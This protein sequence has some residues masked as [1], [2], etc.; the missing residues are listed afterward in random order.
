MFSDFPFSF[1]ESNCTPLLLVI[2]APCVDNYFPFS[3]M[4]FYFCFVTFFPLKLLDSSFVLIIIFC[5]ILLVLPPF[6]T[7]IFV[8]FASPLNMRSFRVAV[9]VGWC[10]SDAAVFKK[11]WEAIGIPF[12][13]YLVEVYRNTVYWLPLGGVVLGKNLA[14][15]LQRMLIIRHN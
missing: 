3:R 15:I 4:P 5:R 11:A 10:G 12:T 9:V 2:N 8:M 13:D 14:R 6:C 7:L 1:Q